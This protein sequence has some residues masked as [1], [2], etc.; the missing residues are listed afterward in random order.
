M[1]KRIGMEVAI[2]AAEAVALCN[3]DVAAVYPITPQSHIAEHMADIIH[4]GRIDSE[5]ITVESEHS[6]IS[7]CA[8][9][10]AAGARA[11]T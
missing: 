6:A 2:A 10:S 1:G 5:F 9:A 8:G 11:Y 4:D 7:A 3:I